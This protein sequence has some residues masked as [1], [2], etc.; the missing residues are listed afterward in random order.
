[1]TQTWT[2]EGGAINYQ[3]II[4]TYWTRMYISWR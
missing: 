1:M 4:I 3:S 2:S